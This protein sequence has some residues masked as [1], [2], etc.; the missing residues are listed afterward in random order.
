MHQTPYIDRIRNQAGTPAI[1]L[2]NI[3]LLR[4]KDQKA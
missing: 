4:A 3:I 1:L 2:G